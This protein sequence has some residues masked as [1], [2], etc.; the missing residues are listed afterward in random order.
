MLLEKQNYISLNNLPDN[1]FVSNSNMINTYKNLSNIINNKFSSNSLSIEVEITINNPYNFYIK[2]LLNLNS[3]LYDSFINQR[4]MFRYYKA[5]TELE[6]RAIS[7]VEFE[8][9]EKS[10]II[11]LKN[12]SPRDL[13]D[14]IVYLYETIERKNF[15]ELE[16]M[17]DDDLADILGISKYN[18]KPLLEKV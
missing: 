2:E 14:K 8:K 15:E 5:A 12:E 3:F 13:K 16:Y 4:K 9:I 10:C 6:E 7:E 17:D 18:L 11:N 1:R